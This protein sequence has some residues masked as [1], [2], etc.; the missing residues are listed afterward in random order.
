MVHA[1][2]T[3]DA[4]VVFGNPVAHSQSPFIHAEF[5]RQAGHAIV[6]TRRH[7][8]PGRFR[9]ALG[10]FR[11]GGG[12]GANVTL[13]FKEEAFDLTMRRS[14][15][16]EQAG[17]VNTLGFDGDVIWGDNTDGVGLVR[18][19]ER[20][21]GL[22][23][24][25]LGIMLLGAGGAAR[26]VIAPLLA[27]SPARLVVVN[28][29]VSRAEGLRRHFADEIEACGFERLP[30]ARF[31]LIVNATSAGL[32]GQAPPLPPAL[33]RSGGAAYDMMYAAEPSPFMG[34]ADG[35]GASIVADGTG[36]LVEQA[37]EAFRQWRGVRPRTGPVID[38]LRR[39]LRARDAD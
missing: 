30:A 36:M 24:A 6:Y 1:D 18:D 21:L 22:R 11:L 31:D 38:A 15:R 12:L 8:E 20:N 7:V 4:Y 14:A 34:W 9:E 13:P 17:A 39:R 23:L 3:I 29:T 28:R 2:S 32:S 37:A 19:L 27:A 16:A 33:L 5:A 26:G 25:G 10:E 35:A